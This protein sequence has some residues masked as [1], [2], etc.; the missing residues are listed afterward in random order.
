[1][2]GRWGGVGVR[3]EVRCEVEFK[4]CK[5]QPNQQQSEIGKLAMRFDSELRTRSHLPPLSILSEE[6]VLGLRCGVEIISL[7]LTLTTL[8]CGVVLVYS[9]CCFI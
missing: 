5:Q 3:C 6:L 8:W 1:V 2:G 7:V 9:P 4:L